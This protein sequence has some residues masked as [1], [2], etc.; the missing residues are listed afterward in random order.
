MLLEGNS[1][2]F[3]T[4]DQQLKATRVNAQRNATE[5][6]KQEKTPK[7]TDASGAEVLTT[8]VIAATVQNTTSSANQTTTTTPFEFDL[9]DFS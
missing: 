2:L 8:T 4:V 7:P 1:L 9:F 6:A 5:M 3:A